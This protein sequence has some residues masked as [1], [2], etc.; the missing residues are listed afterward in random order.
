V[1][2]RLGLGYM[3]TGPPSVLDSAISF[4]SGRASQYG[5]DSAE[6]TLQRLT[7][8]MCLRTILSAG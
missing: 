8:L 5:N 1:T 6:T 2:H 3:R 4:Y 7:E